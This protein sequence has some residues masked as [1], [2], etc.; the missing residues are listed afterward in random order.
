MVRNNPEGLTY[1]NKNQ[2]EAFPRF[3]FGLQ[4]ERQYVVV[5]STSLCLSRFCPISKWRAHALNGLYVNQSC[6]RSKGTERMGSLTTPAS[7]VTAVAGPFPGSLLN[8]GLDRSAIWRFS[9][10]IRNTSFLAS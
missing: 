1:A 7:E 5:S 4:F 6:Y 9:R 2:P 3:F 10:S 8:P